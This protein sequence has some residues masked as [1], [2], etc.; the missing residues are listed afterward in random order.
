[1]QLIK[2]NLSVGN[3]RTPQQDKKSNN[4]VQDNKQHDTTFKRYN[5]ENKI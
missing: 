1:M 5:D 4:V 2:A 3:K